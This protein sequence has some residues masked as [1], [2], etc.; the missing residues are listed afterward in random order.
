[1]ETFSLLR[2]PLWLLCLAAVPF[3]VWRYHRRA[4][5]GFVRF[6][7]LP[8]AASGAWRLHLPFYARLLAFTLLVVA[9]SRPQHGL[10]WEESQMEGIDIQI[11]LDVSGSMAAEDFQPDNRLTVAKDVVKDFV[12]RRRGDRI[13]VV[14]FSGSAMTLAP[15]TGDGVTLERLVDSVRLHT[16]RDGTA[17]GVA[18]ATSAARLRDSAADS[19][20]ILLVTDGVNNAGAIDPRSAAA[21]CAQ[22]DIRVY[23]V[24]VGQEGR[25]LVPV[26]G[27]TGSDGEV[28]Q[29]RVMMDVEVDEPLLREISSLTGG[30]FFHATDSDHLRQIFS[31]IDQLETTPLQVRRLVRYRELFPLLVWGAVAALLLPIPLALV[32]VVAEP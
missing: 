19:K 23:T 27:F 5:S 7:R 4:P 20:V 21:V 30:S 28:R 24:G 3:V 10:A 11:A 22:H 26:Q 17:I 16:L 1:M 8:V 2:S 14:I 15:L 32:G 29:R 25:L 13:G 12:R 9:A 18:L 31:E 6:S